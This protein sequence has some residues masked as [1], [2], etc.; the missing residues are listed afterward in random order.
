MSEAEKIE[1]NEV[2]QSLKCYSERYLKNSIVSL[3]LLGQRNL[4]KTFGAL[5]HRMQSVMSIMA[6]VPVLDIKNCGRRKEH[7]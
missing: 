5:M 7:R 2:I 6:D 4:Y 3:C 1:N